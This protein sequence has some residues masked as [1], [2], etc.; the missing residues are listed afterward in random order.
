MMNIDE[1]R[2]SASKF[3]TVPPGRFPL[4]AELKLQNARMALPDHIPPGLG[5][6]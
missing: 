5:I 2:N 3:E 1:P 4:L 6:A